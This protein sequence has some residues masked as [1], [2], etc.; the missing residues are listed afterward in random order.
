M[1]KEK[2]VEELELFILNY[3][4]PEHWD[5]NYDY[6]DLDHKNGYDVV[7]LYTD[8]GGRYGH[9]D[10]WFRVNEES[11]RKILNKLPD[12]DETDPE[13]FE[14]HGDDWYDYMNAYVEDNNVMKLLC[15]S[16]IMKYQQ[17]YDLYRESYHGNDEVY[18]IPYALEE[19]IERAL[20]Y[21]NLH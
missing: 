17:V 3:Y 12:L 13:M 9:D 1:N 10:V 14:E 6:F 19:L 5:L 21:L 2:K 15:D 18:E 20:R 16:N 4:V 7:V 11:I 8:E